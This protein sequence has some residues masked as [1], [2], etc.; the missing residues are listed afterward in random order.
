MLM[1]AHVGVRR[2]KNGKRDMLT[3]FIE[4][5]GHYSDFFCGQNICSVLN[6]FIDMR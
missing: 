5:E 6:Y 4:E 2:V 1:V 3:K